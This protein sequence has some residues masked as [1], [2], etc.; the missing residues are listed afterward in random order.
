MR[1]AAI[2]KNIA[3]DFKRDVQSFQV[4]AG[5]FCGRQNLNVVTAAGFIVFL[6]LLELIEQQ[7]GSALNG[8]E[9]F[10]QDFDYLG[11]FAL[12]AI[13]TAHTPNAM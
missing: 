11:C 6:P 8:D 1:F 5:Q 4:V 3:C 7:Q 13:S 9:N 12:R 10:V 2:F